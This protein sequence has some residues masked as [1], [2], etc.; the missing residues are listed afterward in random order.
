MSGTYAHRTT[1]SCYST[2]N[3]RAFCTHSHDT[4]KLLFRHVILLLNP[5][6]GLA[7]TL[8]VLPAPRGVSIVRNLR[9]GRPRRPTRG[10]FACS[11]VRQSRDPVS[12]SEVRPAF[13]ST[14]DLLAQIEDLN[15]NKTFY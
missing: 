2:D 5:L 7:R 11:L 10:R 3:K 6:C 8:Q 15:I 13:Y 4:N 12:E 14:G 9:G 1:Y